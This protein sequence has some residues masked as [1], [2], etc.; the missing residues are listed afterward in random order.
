MHGVARNNIDACGG[1]QLDGGQPWFYVDGERVI[2]LGDPVTGHGPGEHGGPVMV[3]GSPW[4]F[5]DGIPVC[6]EGHQCSCGHATTG[7]P[8]FK[9]SE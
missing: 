1:A 2:L 5:I 3:E 4:F 7:S 6:R 9:L 8:W